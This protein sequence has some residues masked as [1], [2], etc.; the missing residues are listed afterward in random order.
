MGADLSRGLV[1]RLQGPLMS[2][3]G[4]KVDQNSP[5][6]A[7]PTR[8]M[9]TGLLGNALGYEHKDRE[10]L[11]RLQD[12]LRFSSRQELKGH[13]IVDFHTVDLSLPRM[14]EKGWTTHGRPE[15]RGGN[16]DNSTG[17]HIRYVHYLAGA[18]VLTLLALV[19][20]SPAHPQ[21]PKLEDLK[22]ALLFPKR[23]L[24]L[25]RKCCIPSTRILLGELE[26]H[27]LRDGLG[28]IPALFD[29]APSGAYL[30][31]WPNEEGG[32]PRDL[33]LPVTDER[34]WTNGVHVGRSILRQGMIKLDPKGFQPAFAKP[35]PSMRDLP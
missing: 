34:D 26:F 31:Q 5:T 28:Q 7:F 9:L 8:S 17:T 3:G 33:V 22:H 24:F 15:G 11:S 35:I 16:K 2:F 10:R 29:A 20:S 14:I 32:S 19:P 4:V 18:C 30:G 13:E 23:P 12:R 27:N 25:G 6:L 1:L 21:D